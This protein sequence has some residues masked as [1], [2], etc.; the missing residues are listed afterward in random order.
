MDRIIVN[1]LGREKRWARLREGIMESFHVYQ[2]EKESIAGNIYL[3]R[4]DKVE[5]GLNAAFINIG[6]GKNGFL[7]I[8]DLPGFLALDENERM[9]AVI[10]RLLHQGQKLLVQVKKDPTGTK[11]PRLTG[12]VE[13]KGRSIV[14]LP[15]GRYVAVSKK[16][17][18]EE[19]KKKWR[20]F[21]SRMK[22][23][24]EGIL[25]R[26]AALLE[27][28]ESIKEQFLELRKQYQDIHSL[29]L[30]KKNP[31]LLHRRDVMKE[32]ILEEMKKIKQAELIIDDFTWK[33]EFQDYLQ[34]NGAS[35]IGE[36]IH[37][38]GSENIFSRYRVDAQIEKAMRKV[39]WLENGATIVI[40]PTEALTVIDVNTG[41]FTGKK[42]LSQTVFRTN[43]M[44]A[45][46]IARQLK[47]RNLSGIILIDFIE[48][49]SEQHHSDIIQVLKEGLKE[50]GKRTTIV[51]F[52][53][54]GILQLTRKKTKQ[55]L[56]E[57]ISSECPVC[58]GYGIVQSAESLAYKLERELQELSPAVEDKVII[59]AT[60][61]VQTAFKG[62]S[63]HYLKE[64][65]KAINKKI[66]FQ[67]AKDCHPFYKIK[68]LESR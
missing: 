27:S 4:V 12:I 38:Q 41:K 63:S 21:G 14:F 44:A 56:L 23:E 1:A 52:T 22:E 40:E 64:M 43:E 36:V 7:H 33:N 2:P 57:Y 65:E 6:E 58:S 15:E 10:S 35:L 66:E 31:A 51:G 20:R 30:S 42:D 32:D 53:E 48:M 62:E 3:G 8:D 59:Q 17:S 16:A 24:Q 45:K 55:P 13:I 34:K 50:D 46:E 26:T 54:L 19:Q 39:V 49:K 5:K 29:S 67:T 25:F 28:E 60:E 9:T 37:F 47:I 61:D 68:R 18:S 11:G